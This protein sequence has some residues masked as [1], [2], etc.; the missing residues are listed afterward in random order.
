MV[1]GLDNA[2]GDSHCLIAKVDFKLIRRGEVGETHDKV[3]RPE[4]SAARPDLAPS[5]TGPRGTRCFEDDSGDTATLDPAKN[6]IDDLGVKEIEVLSV[7]NFK[8]DGS[9]PSTT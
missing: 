2:D 8:I 5:R 3:G 9:I 6:G 7:R 1:A 4:G